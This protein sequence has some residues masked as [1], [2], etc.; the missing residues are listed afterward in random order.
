MAGA[1]AVIGAVAS[2]VG[3]IGSISAQNKS[4]DAQRKQQAAQRRRS[5]RQNVR[6]A[7]IARASIA[8]TAQGV[9]AAGS[10]GAFGGSGAVSSNLGAAAGHASSQSILSGII[11]RQNQR[12][13]IF[14]GVAGLGTNL[15]NASGVDLFATHS[16]QSVPSGNG[17]GGR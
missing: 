12:A 15:F 4:A 10:S 2:V 11:T 1:A 13:N 7:Q 3:T 14:S 5:T 16:L 8:S 17:G 9:G 6:Q